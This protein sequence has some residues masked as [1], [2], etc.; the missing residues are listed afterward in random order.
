MT[1]KSQNYS[2]PI[3][4]DENGNPDDLN[5]NKN[6]VKV[7]P[8]QPLRVGIICQEANKEDIEYY[9]DEFMAINSKLGDTVK[10][11]FFGYDKDDGN[12][13]LEGINYEYIPSCSIVHYFK[14]LPL[15]KLDVLFI[16]L[17]NIGNYNSHS[18]N[19]NK[20]LEAGLFKIPIITINI[21]PYQQIIDD[22]INGFI[23]KEKHEFVPYLEHLYLKRMLVKTVGE[24]AYQS[25]TN[26]FNYSPENIRMLSDLFIKPNTDIDG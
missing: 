17:I 8:L 6:I 10:L 18:E 9:R 1:D 15:L 20:Y 2:P 14:Q 13:V 11:V 22:K 12:D 3:P 24:N 16:P 5:N 26:H 19:Y 25:V 4:E 7:A 21:Y 23:Y